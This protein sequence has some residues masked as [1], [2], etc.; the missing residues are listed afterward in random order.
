M[1]NKPFIQEQEGI[2]TACQLSSLPAS[3]LKIRRPD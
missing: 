3:K 2:L 1:Q